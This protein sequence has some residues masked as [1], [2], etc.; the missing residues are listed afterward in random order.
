MGPYNW[1][2]CCNVGVCHLPGERIADPSR[3]AGV[4]LFLV[5][6]RVCMK[7]FFVL[8]LVEFNYQGVN[9]SADSHIA[10]V[11]HEYLYDKSL[12]L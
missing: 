9:S 8:S 11:Q 2:S 3:C 4:V 7:K 5:G 1:C 12:T 6:E 10:E